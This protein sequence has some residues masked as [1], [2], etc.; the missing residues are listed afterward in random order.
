MTPCLDLRPS[1]WDIVCEILNKHLPDRKVLAFGS[2]ATWTAKEYSDLDLAVL[3]DEP[4]LLNVKSA[5]TEGFSESDLPFKVDIVE[6]ARIDE[7]FRDKIRR[8]GLVVKVPSQKSASPSCPNQPAQN[9][10][11]NDLDRSLTHHI[12]KEHE[13]LEYKEWRQVSL[14]EL[15]ELTLS[16][17]DKKSKENERS[18]RLCNYTDVYYNMFIHANMNFMSATATE[19]E[20]KKCTLLSGDVVITKDSE[21]HDDIGVPALVK[22]NVRDL[23]CGYHLAILRPRLSEIDGTYLYY[24]L[25]TKDAQRQFHAY[26]NGITRFGLRKYDIGQVEIPLPSLPE[27]RVIARILSS[28]DEKIESNRSIDQTLEEIAQTLFKSWFV[29][30][31]PVRAKMEG[32]DT[33]LPKHIDDL[34][35]DRLIN[36]EVGEIPEGWG[37]KALQ[38]CFNLT[39]GQSPPSSTYNDKGDGIPFFQ[40][41]T[42]FGFRYPQNR[43]FCT[44]PKRIAQPG[45]TLISVRAPVGDINLALAKCCIGRGLSALRHKSNSLSYTYYFAKALQKRIASYEGTGT[46]Y[47][48]INRKQFEELQILEPTKK[49]VK[50]FHTIVN[51]IDMSIRKNVMEV[52]D[53]VQLRETLLPKLI[54]GRVRIK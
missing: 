24:A 8:E 9:C 54:S 14:N 53:L 28:L 27:Q 34:F 29:N 39:M 18:V 45:D 17:V 44:A 1:H 7:A 5:L 38:N 32:R 40:G 26:S 42:D 11:G 48:S 6:W 33:G 41:R 49:L 21:K 47:G 30:F 46:V 35:P 25:S 22:E 51:P 10:Q 2:R 23:V 50:M 12:F 43:K 19:N 13:D 52:N 31:E 4:L 15:I 20:V 36:A 3:G 16:S 37:I